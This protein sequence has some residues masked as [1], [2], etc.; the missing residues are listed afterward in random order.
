MVARVTGPILSGVNT[1]YLYRRSVPGCKQP[2]LSYP[3][4]SQAVFRNAQAACSLW[5]WRSSIGG[6]HS[7]RTNADPATRINGERMV[8]DLTSPATGARLNPSS[9]CVNISNSHWLLAF[10]QQQ[11]NPA[12]GNRRMEFGRGP[13]GRKAYHSHFVADFQF[14]FANHPFHVP[15]NTSVAGPVM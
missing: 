14:G 13:T 11:I 8:F 7:P 6:C 10:D 9:P 5:C 2:G 4:K 15:S 3:A 1:T 12:G